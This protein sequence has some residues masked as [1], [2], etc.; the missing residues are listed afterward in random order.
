VHAQAVALALV[1]TVATAKGV[2]VLASD[3]IAK[4]G[5]AP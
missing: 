3:A 2:V 5:A 4:M 1:S